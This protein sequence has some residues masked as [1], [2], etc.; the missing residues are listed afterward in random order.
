MSG[1]PD[2]ITVRT[3]P[4][5]DP[6]RDYFG[7]RPNV[8][9]ADQLVSY[10][11]GGHC[12]LAANGTFTETHVAAV[13][14]AVCD[15]RRLSGLGGP[16]FV[17]RDATSL[18]AVAATT[19]REVFAA[20]GV[21]AVAQ[22]GDGVVP[23]PVVSW[24]VV[25]HNRGGTPHLAD[26]VVLGGAD[27]PPGA[28]VFRYYPPH[29]GPAGPE[30][31]RWVEERANEYLLRD[32]AGVRRPTIGGADG[33]R[34]DDFIG[35]YVDAIRDVIDVDAI[36]A[37]GVVLGVDPRD[38]AAACWRVVAQ[39]HGLEIEAAGRPASRA[40]LAVATD[41]D[42]GG[43]RIVAPTG[44]WLDPDDFLGVAIPYL[45]GHRPGWP[46]GAAVGLTPA[47]GRA[48]DRAVAA[49]GRAVAWSPP[50]FRWFADG[51]FDGSLCVAAEGPRATFVRRDG[52]TWTT[53][54]D[55]LVMGLVAAEI[56]AR[57]GKHP[58]ELCSE[59]AA[60]VETGGRA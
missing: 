36:R 30:V 51:L 54:A 31:A 14:Q 29:G 27:E 35:R 47:A 7:R 38:G 26:G 22:A 13:A 15:H 39:V 2:G 24:A 42:G 55:G 44:G 58:A 32:N 1:I 21:R 48:L 60:E 56:V 49:A 10:G 6:A 50:G 19:T 33:V 45:L 41:A 20:N 16:L 3:L 9:D 34:E 43:C 46:A 59:M 23:A 4:P 25:T 57:T 8:D 37:A 11:A 12:G 28:S 5:A 52:A 18:A 40:H 17:G 53:D